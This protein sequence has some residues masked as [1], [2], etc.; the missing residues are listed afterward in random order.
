MVDVFEEVEEGLR[1]EQWRTLA[2]RWLPWVLGALALALA[3]A[4]AVWGWDA[5]RSRT[6]AEAS[7][8]Y[9]RGV[10]ALSQ[11]DT[12]AADTAFTEAADAGSPAYRA[13]ALSQR[14]GILAAREQTTEAVALFDEAAEASRD[15]L[16]ADQARLKAAFLLMDT[17]SLEDITARLTPLAEEGRPFRPL[18]REA[19][20]LARLQHGETAEARREFVLLSLAQ[21]VPEGLQQR[22]Q[23]AIAM[24]DAGT[25]S[26]IAAIV[27][28]AGQAAATA[29]AA[30]ARP[31]AD[32]E[33]PTAPAAPAASPDAAAPR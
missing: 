3:I 19:L 25:A 26:S 13:L 14:A 33:A 32:A 28:A 20:A 23:A 17:A 22:A 21:D 18:A 31:G 4:L 10:E 6:A 11:G 9:A 29:E 24:I 16:L 8:A 30:A 2:R 15:P 7:Q 27:R 12:A 1:S 5:W